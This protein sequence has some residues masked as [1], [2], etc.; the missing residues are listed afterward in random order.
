M[1]PLLYVT[2]KLK[3]ILDANSFKGFNISEM[4]VTKAE[5]FDNN[6]HQNKPLPQFYWLQV[7]GERSTA[8]IYIDDSSNLNITDTFLSFLK[9]Y[10]TLNYLEVKPERNEFDDILDQ[11]I[12]ESNSNQPEKG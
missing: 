11:M 12:S 1:P 8:D 9:S 3:K 7:N 4:K 5:C 2:E 10:A 6:Y